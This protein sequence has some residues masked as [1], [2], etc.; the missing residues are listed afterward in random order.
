MILAWNFIYAL[1]KKP[2]RKAFLKLSIQKILTSKIR[3]KNYENVIV[4]LSDYISK[5]GFSILRFKS[6]NESFVE[7]AEKYLD[8]P[9]VKDHI[10]FY[11]RERENI[12]YRDICSQIFQMTNDEFLQFERKRDQFANM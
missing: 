12:Y 7:F 8:Q 5:N 6:K 9:F 2:K 11:L 3:S 10:I 1:F 4:G